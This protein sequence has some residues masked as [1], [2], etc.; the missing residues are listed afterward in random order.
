MRRV[1]RRALP[2]STR[3]ALASRQRASG[4]VAAA[5]EQWVSFRRSRAAQ[6]VIQVLSEMAG[7]R[8][9]CVY[10]SDSR[11]GDVDHYLPIAIDFTRTFSWENLLWVCPQCNRNKN[12]SFPMRDGVPLLINPAVERPWSRL[13]LD[14]AS[15]VMS[16]RYHGDAFDESG[17]ATLN[18]FDLLNHEALIEGRARTIVRV[19]KAT[20]DV[21]DS[22]GGHPARE[23]LCREV[24]EDDFGVSAWFF[25]SDGRQESPFRDVR[26]TSPSLWRRLASLTL[27]VE[28]GSS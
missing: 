1:H 26:E 7:V 10:C 4:D 22:G 3:H 19:R 5:R 13:V 8:Q 17:A 15:G 12:A 28:Y 18:V 23:A 9:R 27:N 14:T 11:S 6:E 2:I 24:R 25:L 16:A 20:Q 21:F